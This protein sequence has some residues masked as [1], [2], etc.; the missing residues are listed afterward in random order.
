HSD[1]ESTLETDDSSDHPALRL[2]LQT[3]S[4]LPWEVATRVVTGRQKSVY[5]NLKD[6]AQRTRIGKSHLATLADADALGSLAGDRRAAIWESLWHEDSSQERPLFDDLDS[7][8]ALP[9]SLT[10]MTPLEE[11]YADY[12]TTGLSLKAHP[13]SF[14]RSELERKRCVTAAQLSEL[15]DGRHVRVGG[16][17]LLRQRPSTAK[18]ITFVTLE[19]E[20][21][22]INLVLFQAVWERFFLVARTSNAWLVD[23]KLENRKGVI[24]VVVGR[25]T[26]LSDEVNGLQVRSRDFH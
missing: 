14:V 9:E 2:G 4:G 17:V 18:G 24:H 13:I 11:V 10:P 5:R 3:I 25:I 15:R 23:G 1:V 19:D 22:S 6:L 16:L 20:T 21:G 7:E 12:H 26:N 8:D